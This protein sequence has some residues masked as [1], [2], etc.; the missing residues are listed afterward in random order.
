MAHNTNKVHLQSNVSP[1]LFPLDYV[2]PIITI[3]EYNDSSKKLGKLQPIKIS[4]LF[5]KLFTGI[6]DILTLAHELRIFL[7]QLQMLI[8]FCLRRILHGLKASTFTTLL[9]CHGVVWLDTSISEEKFWEGA[10][11]FTSILEFRHILVRREV[12]VF[13]PIPLVELKFRSSILPSQIHIF[14]VITR[15]EPSIRSLVQ[16]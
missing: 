9:F 11:S 16:C 5:Y 2:G 12:N 4:K 10:E 14:K 3:V 6:K 15:V 13:K 7:I 8:C 1:L